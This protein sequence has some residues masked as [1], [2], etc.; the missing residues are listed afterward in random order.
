MK[1]ACKDHHFEPYTLSQR[2]MKV[3]KLLGLPDCDNWP[4]YL[5]ILHRYSSTYIGVICYYRKL[6]LKVLLEVFI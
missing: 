4:K 3:W 2:K 1:C 6:F 5:L